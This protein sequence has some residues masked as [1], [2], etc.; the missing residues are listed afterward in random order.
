MDYSYFYCCL[1]INAKFEQQPEKKKGILR[2]L[3]IPMSLSLH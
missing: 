1:V 3:V 2:H